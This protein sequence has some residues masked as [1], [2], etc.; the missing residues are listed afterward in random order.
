[1]ILYILIGLPAS[2][3]SFWAKEYIKTSPSVN[4]KRVNKDLLREMFDISV[5]SGEK[6]NFINSI[7]SEI[8]RKS[9]KKGYDVIVDNTNLNKRARKEFHDIARSIGNVAVIEKVFEVPLEECILRDK[10]RTNSV[11]ESVIRGMFDRYLKNGYPGGLIVSYDEI[12]HSTSS[13]SS[14]N[15]TL[16]QDKSLQKAA[17][18][19][20]DGTLAI[21]TGRNP[22]DASKCEQDLPNVYV[23]EMLKTMYCSG[24]KIFIFS[25]REDKFEEQTRN[26]LNKHIEGIPYELRMRKSDDKRNDAIVKKEIY[27]STIKDKFFVSAIIDD[28]LKVCKMWHELGLPMFRVGDP[29]ASF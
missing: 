28:R 11:G 17:I 23:F 2:G 14:V 3:K 8:V 29:E 9:L 24:N 1:M 19:D 18:F 16:C 10:N 21:I 26:W 15:Q 5:W 25:G 7:Q 13:D 12:I 20:I 27:E 22:Y 6:E 4:I